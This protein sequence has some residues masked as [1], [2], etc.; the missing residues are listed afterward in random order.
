MLLE[1]ASTANSD[2]LTMS[3]FGVFGNK[4]ASIVAS[5][6]AALES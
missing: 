1:D 3:E 5:A 4:R 6:S 2:M